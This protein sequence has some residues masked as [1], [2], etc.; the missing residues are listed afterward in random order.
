MTAFSQ[1]ALLCNLCIEDF[2]NL[3]QP[4]NEPCE[5]CTALGV[6]SLRGTH[7]RK[8]QSSAILAAST[9]ISS[10]SVLT[11]TS[12]VVG[13][14]DLLRVVTSSVSER[15][16]NAC[17]INDN[18][19]P[20]GSVGALIDLT[21]DS[22]QSVRNIVSVSSKTP[23]PK[24]GGKRPVTAQD[25]IDSKQPPKKT[26][27]MPVGATK[28][29]PSKLPVPAGQIPQ[30]TKKLPVGANACSTPSKC[31]AAKVSHAI[32]VASAVVKGKSENMKKNREVAKKASVS[33]DKVV[34]AA[35]VDEQI[36]LSWSQCEKFREKCQ[37]KARKG[38]ESAARADAKSIAVP[39]LDGT[40]RGNTYGVFISRDKSTRSEGKFNSDGLQHGYGIMTWDNGPSPSG[41]PG[42]AYEGQ[43]VDG[44]SCGR[45]YY[46]W[47]NGDEYFGLWE[48]NKKTDSTG[49]A[50]FRTPAGMMYCGD[51]RDD[52]KHGFGTMIYPKGERYEGQW[53]K[54]KRHGKATWTGTDGSVFHGEYKNDQANGMGHQTWPDGRKQIGVWRY[55][56]FIQGKVE[57]WPDTE[58]EGWFYDGEVATKKKETLCSMGH[59][60]LVKHGKGTLTD[61]TGKVIRSGSW[62]MDKQK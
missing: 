17:G 3:N 32:P 48:N 31:S 16:N 15:S 11:E 36:S 57:R 13:R 4:L 8:E 45:G 34:A 21:E 9:S 62:V 19:K 46:L 53:V 20:A 5:V 56:T 29:T 42:K 24:K 47:E 14:E 6:N 30:K 1:R 37:F 44:V 55:G 12:A 54:G 50:V 49:T 52:L 18:S 2:F 10:S 35:T 28:I 40:F 27:K 23:L 25:S 58:Q 59:F 33:T 39:D 22:P 61:S 60:K 7:P 26:K 43:F 41:D 51:F 38:R